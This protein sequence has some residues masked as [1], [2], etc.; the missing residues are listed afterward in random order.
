MN[1]TDFKSSS[2]DMGN[3]NRVKLSPEISKNITTY[4]D[5]NIIEI[6]RVT[7][8]HGV[9]E[10]TDSR[11]DSTQQQHGKGSSA[12]T[13]QDHFHIKKDHDSEKLIWFISFL[14]H[15]S[16][17]LSTF[18]KD[19]FFPG[20]LWILLCCDISPMICRFEGCI[21][22]PLMAHQVHAEQIDTFRAS[23]NSTALWWKHHGLAI[24]SLVLEMFQT[25]HAVYFEISVFAF[26]YTSIWFGLYVIWF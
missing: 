22:G 3:W 5:S 18:L 15:L 26:V 25:H 21:W 23:N 11:V 2:A 4:S 6:N 20:H 24:L 17:C 10:S 7:V 13:C 16:F 12:K 8:R 19:A 9:K 14:F 1:F